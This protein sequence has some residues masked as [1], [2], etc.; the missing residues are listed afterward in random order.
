MNRLCDQPASRA[1]L[2]QQPE[3]TSLL[4]SN[5]N[6]QLR[7]ERAP[8]QAGPD[9]VFM[10]VTAGGSWPARLEPSNVINTMNTNPI[11]GV[12]PL[13]ESP[14]PTAAHAALPSMNRRLARRNLSLER[15][16]SMP[17]ALPSDV[18]SSAAAAAEAAVSSR[19]P[20]APAPAGLERAATA[21][22][23]SLLPEFPEDLDFLDAASLL[24]D[25][26]PDFSAGDGVDRR[27]GSG[28]DGEGFDPWET[29]FGP[30]ATML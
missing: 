22:P 25:G 21:L 6:H 30:S 28:A 7:P 2:N 13:Q 14:A 19:Q 1:W 15:G 27:S 4:S 23:N 24:G 12:L 11:P 5:W 29:L 26:A 3:L 9:A 8:V 10:L 18:L 20:P 17:H 16:A